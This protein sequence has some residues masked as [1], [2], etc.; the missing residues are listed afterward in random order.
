MRPAGETTPHRTFFTELYRGGSSGG[1]R[2]STRGPF[3]NGAPIK[4]LVR[5]SAPCDDDDDDARRVL[6]SRVDGRRRIDPRCDMTTSMTVDE[7]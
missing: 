3:V 6:I 1:S 4:P 7:T 2:V 5:Q